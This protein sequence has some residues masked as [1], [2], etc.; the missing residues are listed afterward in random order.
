VEAGKPT[1]EAERAARRKQGR[2]AGV[3]H[4]TKGWVRG[5]SKPGKRFLLKPAPGSKCGE[6]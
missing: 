5:F 2:E 1:A 6:F 4:Q 3:F